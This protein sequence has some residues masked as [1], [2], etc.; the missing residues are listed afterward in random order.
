MKKKKEKMSAQLLE[1]INI[2]IFGINCGFFHCTAVK[3]NAV[4]QCLSINIIMYLFQVA[5]WCDSIVIT[6][7]DVL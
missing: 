3:P 1:R 4:Y 2:I 7:Y 6:N 5:L